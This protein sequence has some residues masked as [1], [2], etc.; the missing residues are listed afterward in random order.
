MLDMVGGWGRLARRRNH[1]DGEGFV[2]RMPRADV[3]VCLSRLENADIAGLMTGH[4]DVVGKV[5]SEAGGIDDLAGRTGD[6]VGRTGNLALAGVA[7]F[8]GWKIALAHCLDMSGS[9]AVAL[10]AADSELG[11]GWVFESPV[12]AGD[13]I[14]PAAVAEDAARR[15]GAVKAKVG[16]FVSGR[17]APAHG[18]GVE[19]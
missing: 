17:W 19:G 14:W 16:E 7:L 5:G 11:K 10:F 4:A 15:D 6:L 12:A 18:F 3:P 1:E 13:R 8:R 2:E 9:W